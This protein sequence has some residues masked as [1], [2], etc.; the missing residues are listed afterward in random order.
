MSRGSLKI[1][2]FA[3]E[4]EG[5]PLEPIFASKLPESDFAERQSINTS[6][7]VDPET[8]EN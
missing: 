2:R 4:N 7:E 6:R 1:L 3:Q 5:A 8:D